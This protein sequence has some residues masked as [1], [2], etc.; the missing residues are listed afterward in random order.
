MTDGNIAGIDVTEA[1]SWFLYLGEIKTAGLNRFLVEPVTRRYGKPASCIHI[2]PDVVAYYP[3]GNFL[4]VGPGSEKAGPDKHGRQNSR[5][6]AS[7]FA[8]LAAADESVIALIR[9]ILDIQDE[10]IVN[11]FESSPEFHPLGDDRVRILGPDPDVSVPMNNKLNQ[12]K[13]ATDINIPVPKGAVCSGTDEV[14]RIAEQL[15]SRGR[16]AFVSGAYSA[17]GSNSIIA[18]TAGEITSRFRRTTEGFLVTEFLEHRYDPTVL[19]IIASENEIYIAS[20]ADQNI[21]GTRFTGSTFPTVLGEATVS[22]LKEITRNIGSWMGK[23]GYRGV[24]GCDFVVDKN[25]EVFFIEINARK[26]GTTMETTLAM[27]HNLPG[28]PTLPELEM[29]AVLEG[30]LPD[31]L[32]EMDSRNSPIC[33]GT[34]NYKATEKKLVKNYVPQAMNEETLF[35]EA[36]AGKGG[37]IVLDHVGPRTHI[38]AGGFIARIVAAGPTLDDVRRELKAG[39]RQVHVS[40][41]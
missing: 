36:A 11:V 1:R 6:S 20:V 23:Q 40:V 25:G 3:E 16:K 39:A 15:F 9:R 27:I 21:D 14:L 13:M 28:S 37:Y 34:Y 26:Q 19:G 30:R 32:E 17:G 33:W 41:G 18:S 22:R 12:Y 7:Q 31:G 24:F 10:L 4:V 8:V 5:M 29:M 38:S 2:V 35:R